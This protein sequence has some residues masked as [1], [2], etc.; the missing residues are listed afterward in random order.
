MRESEAGLML[1]RERGECGF[2]SGSARSLHQQQQACRQIATACLH[3][4]SLPVHNSRVVKGLPGGLWC[5]KV[6]EK[7]GGG[8]G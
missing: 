4:L 2:E 3:H 6:G 5:L 1:D 8:G 7:L